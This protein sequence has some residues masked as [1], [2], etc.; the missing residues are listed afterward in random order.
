MAV[1]TFYP[2]VAVDQGMG[3]EGEEALSKSRKHTGDGTGVERPFCEGL[4]S[5]QEQESVV[6]LYLSKAF[7]ITWHLNV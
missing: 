7:S 6:P 3:F 1:G 4:R 5:R 2:T